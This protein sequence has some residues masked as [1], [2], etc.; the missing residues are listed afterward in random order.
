MSGSRIT[1]L[2]IPGE[3]DSEDEIEK[4]TQWVVENLGPRRP[5]PFYCF[6][7]RLQDA[8]ETS[9]SSRNRGKGA[10]DRAEKRNPLPLH[11]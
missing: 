3:N 8:G 2:L 7:S 4:L 11:R 10:E 1:N 6:P 5:Y 9:H